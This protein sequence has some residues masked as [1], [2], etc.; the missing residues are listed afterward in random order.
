M[1]QIRRRALVALIPILMVCGFLPSA[2]GYVLHGLHLLE[3]MSKEIG[4]AKTLRIEQKLTVFDSAQ[5]QPPLEFDETV[6]YLIPDAFHSQISSGGVERIQAVNRGR[7]LTIVDGS[8]VARK[9]NDYD[10]YKDV[11]LYNSRVLLEDRLTRLGVDTRISSLG[12]FQGRLA[13]VLGAQYPD[14]Y[15]P[16]LWLD[17]NTFRPFRWIIKPASSEGSGDALEI[18]YYGWRKVEE[19]WYPVRIEFYSGEQ[20]LRYIQ[21]KSIQFNPDLSV[22]LFDIDALRSKY[23]QRQ[24]S[25]PDHTQSGEQSEVQQTI[26]RFE[27]I[28]E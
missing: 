25:L 13:Y 6:S 5:E 10:R 1:F 3:M 12:R 11:F 19:I 28:L 16:Q 2:S 26:R 9:E 24:P 20:L 27:K 8:L 4:S 14:E 23:P 18:R 17:K 7:S 15:F 21:V 22:K